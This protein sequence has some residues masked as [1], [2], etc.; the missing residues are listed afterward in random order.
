[1]A[2][3]H[4]LVPAAVRDR[5]I[6][7]KVKMAARVLSQRGPERWMRRFGIFNGP[8]KD[9]LL[10]DSTKPTSTATITLRAGQIGEASRSSWRVWTC[11]PCLHRA[12]F[13][14]I[15]ATIVGGVPGRSARGSAPRCRAGQQSLRGNPNVQPTIRRGDTQRVPDLSVARTNEFAPTMTRPAWSEASAC[16]ARRHVMFAPLR[17]DH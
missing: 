2:R 13:P 12:S 8:L 15:P 11:V 4:H 7:R 16:L 1:M 6:S 14:G 3:Y 9:K 5:A 10:L 17:N